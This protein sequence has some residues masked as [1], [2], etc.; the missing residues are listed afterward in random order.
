MREEDY[1]EDMDDEYGKYFSHP[2]EGIDYELSHRSALDSYTFNRE[3]SEG[4]LESTHFP[5]TLLI[6]GVLM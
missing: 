6:P 1:C 3:V 2:T 4:F 5:L